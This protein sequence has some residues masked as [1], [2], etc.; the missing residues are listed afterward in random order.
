MVDRSLELTQAFLLP[1][2]RLELLIRSIRATSWDTETRPIA[3][4]QL[5]KALRMRAMLARAPWWN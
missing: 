1:W 3:K 2:P 5:L 4:T